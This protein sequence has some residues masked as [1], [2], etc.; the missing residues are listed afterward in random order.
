MKIAIA[1]D[2][3]DNFGNLQKSLEI[4]AN[5][6]CEYF[7]FAGDFVTPPG[8]SLLEKFPGKI[9]M[10]WGNNEGEK[11]GFVKKVDELDN[12]TMHG[13]VF[14][15]EMDEKKIFMNH[16]PRIAEL[17][18]KSGEFDISIHGHTHEMRQEYAGNT[19]LLCPGNLSGWNEN[20]GAPGFV[21]L[22][23]ESM[24][25]EHIEL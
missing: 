18:A 15:T 16:F 6:N 9:E 2:C 5:N 17:A 7:L 10:V 14:E 19:L 20:K 8:L 11:I 4:A 23:T 25:L 21:I 13:D 12:T 24:E 3:H 22:E 1:S